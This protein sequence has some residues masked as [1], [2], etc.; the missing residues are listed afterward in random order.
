MPPPPPPPPDAFGQLCAGGRSG[1]GRQFKLTPAHQTDGDSLVGKVALLAALVAGDLAGSGHARST[2]CD[3]NR[4]GP[5]VEKEQGLES[6][7]QNTHLMSLLPPPPPPPI[8]PPPPPPPPPNPPP[9][10]PLRP[11]GSAACS[12]QSR[13]YRRKVASGR[14]R[15]PLT[16]GMRVEL[17][18]GSGSGSN[19]G[20]R[21]VREVVSW[22]C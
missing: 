6:A 1:D 2:G 10:A 20:L 9:P 16:S 4:P 12:S 15:A 21:V 14:N 8:P 19:L 22:G 17:S 3:V 5:R 11:V 18:G 7:K 13:R